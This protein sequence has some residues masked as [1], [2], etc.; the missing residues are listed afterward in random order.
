MALMGHILRHVPVSLRDGAELVIV[1]VSGVERAADAVEY[2]P[3]FRRS[4]RLG[5]DV[6]PELDGMAL[7]NGGVFAMVDQFRVVGVV[8]HV[9]V[10]SLM[11]VRLAVS[12]AAFGADTRSDRL[13]MGQGSI[14]DATPFLDQQRVAHIMQ[15][16][17]AAT[18]E[19]RRQ[20][21]SVQIELSDPSL[22]A[23]Y[24]DAVAVYEREPLVIFAVVWPCEQGKN[25]FPFERAA[26]GSFDAEGT[27][28]ARAVDGEATVEAKADFGCFDWL[29]G[30]HAIVSGY[31]PVKSEGNNPNGLGLFVL[32][33]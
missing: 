25:P 2:E 9:I 16:L 26:L 7:N 10:S 12:T 20:H 5:A 1:A 11:P 30:H 6:A 27:M 32:P 14:A 29:H 18:C 23:P 28:A 3:A 13:G 24:V 33:R 31:V 22:A 21:P 19:E 17:I 8:V 4:I 15:L